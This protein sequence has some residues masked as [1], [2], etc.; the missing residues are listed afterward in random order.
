MRLALTLLALLLATGSAHAATRE[1]TMVATEA[2]CPSTGF[3]WMPANVTVEVGDEVVLT[4]VNPKAN[5]GIH[6]LHVLAPIDQATPIRSPGESGAEDVLRFNVTRAGTVAFVC[7]VH[8]GMRGELVVA[9]AP[10]P[11]PSS[12]PQVDAAPA[13]FALVALAVAA[14]ARR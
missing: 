11:S 4:F 14:L 9:P 12:R 7:D 3:C 10:Q 5:R 6:D 13:A 2:G 8:A 1:A